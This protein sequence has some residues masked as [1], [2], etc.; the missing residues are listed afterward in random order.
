MLFSLRLADSLS[1]RHF[2]PSSTG[3]YPAA[4]ITVECRFLSLFFTVDG[5][6]FS[7]F[8]C[9]LSFLCPF[10]LF[11]WFLH[12]VPIWCK[13]IAELQP[14]LCHYLTWPGVHKGRRK[15]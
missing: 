7:A 13:F 1:W 15:A 6:N 10:V 8:P 14:S 11:F 2:L 12:A 4:L 9:K 3:W 5:V